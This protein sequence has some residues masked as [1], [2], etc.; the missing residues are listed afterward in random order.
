M[1]K[2]TPNRIGV[3]RLTL[4]GFFSGVG[5]ISFIY[6]L[7]EDRLSNSSAKW[8]AS[9]KLLKIGRIGGRGGTGVCNKFRP[10]PREQGKVAT[11]A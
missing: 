9:A 3:N 1:T 11:L 2:T 6:A 10:L 7:L 4:E 5:I 8:G